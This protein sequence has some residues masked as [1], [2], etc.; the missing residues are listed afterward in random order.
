MMS[1]KLKSQSSEKNKKNH[2][3]IISPPIEDN[4]FILGQAAHA[5]VKTH[6]LSVLNV[7]CRSINNCLNDLRS[8]AKEIKPLIV[9]AVEIW[10]PKLPSLKIIGYSPPELKIRVDKKGGG[11]AIWVKDTIRYELLENINKLKLKTVEHLAI[12]I[13]IGSKK[14]VIINVYRPPNAKV[15]NSMIDLETLF[16]AAAELNKPILA[17]GDFNINLL[18]DCSITRQYI[19]LLEK[20]Q[21]HQIV[22]EPTRITSKSE[23]LIDHT[24]ISPKIVAYAGVTEHRISDHQIVLSWAMPIKNTCNTSE[25]DNSKTCREKQDV[26]A[27][28]KNLNQIDWEEWWET[29]RENNSNDI[30]KDL[31]QIITKNIVTTTKKTS[32][33]EPRKPW[34]SN[35]T[36]KLKQKLEIKRRKFLKT[37]TVT[38]EI[39]YTNLVSAYKKSQRNDSQNYYKNK[40]QLAQ[41]NS[42]KVWDVINEVLERKV[43]NSAGNSMQFLQI[44]NKKLE[45]KTDISNGFNQ[46]YKEMAPK[47]AKTIE[48]PEKPYNHFLQNVSKPT[49]IFNLESTNEDS[50]MEIISSLTPKTS[51]GFDKISNKLLKIIAPNIVAPLTKAINK[52]IHEGVFPQILKTAK[53]QPLHKSGDRALPSNYRPISQ[54]SSISKVLEKT[55]TKQFTAH[56]NRENIISSKQFGFR[57]QHSTIHPLLITRDFIEKSRNLGNF[58]ILVTLDLSK[59]F[60]TVNTE[61]IL[62]DKLAHY[63]CSEKTENWFKS[64]FRD[65]SQ[66]VTWEDHE[67]ETTELHNISVVQGSSIGPQCFSIYIN[68]L[69]EATKFKTILFADDTN[70]I[71]SGKNLKELA[72]R[73]NNELESVRQYMAANKLSLNVKKT[74]FMVFNPVKKGEKRTEEDLQIVIGQQKLEEVKEV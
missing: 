14:I 3:K 64:F 62:P 27:T 34:V 21:L 68:D 29:I 10:N 59:A 25:K 36:I 44:E 8:V 70:L 13:E 73:A 37:R 57:K 69:A 19:S 24:I 16:K 31:H 53:L 26:E 74:V 55:A 42:K 65:R 28:N 67:S 12:E 48:K 52:S 30:F 15:E 5:I 63:G 20:Y 2:K 23:T 41:S 7:N 46:Y 66:Y 56:L 32:R 22:K 35:N 33:R 38:A 9:N 60:D 39:N 49:E 58:T 72:A 50:V 51:S 1:P 43:T 47:L 61:K 17:T 4:P 18:N 45:S 6:K 54:L 40:L 71:L 11:L